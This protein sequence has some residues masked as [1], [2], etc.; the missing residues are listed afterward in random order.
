M[1]KHLAISLI[2]CAVGA[3]AFAALLYVQAAVDMN[4]NFTGATL[5]RILYMTKVFR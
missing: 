3:S 4:Y 2:L 1:K 5:T